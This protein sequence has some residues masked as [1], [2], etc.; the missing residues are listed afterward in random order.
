MPKLE[1]FR[2]N[3]LHLQ[4][5][6]LTMTELQLKNIRLMRL[7]KIEVYY[8]ENPHSFS[9]LAPGTFIKCKV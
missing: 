8:A 2:S 5:V 6:T 7:L 4:N 9:S 1:Q 3:R